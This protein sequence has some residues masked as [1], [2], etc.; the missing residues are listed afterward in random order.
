[1]TT[2]RRKGILVLLASLY[3]PTQVALG[4][5]ASTYP[6]RPLRI[7]VPFAA[8]GP[9][10]LVARIVA[11]ELSRRIGQPVLVENRTGAAGNIGTDFVAKAAPDG[12]TWLV[13][14]SA[15]IAVNLALYR[16]LPYD[17]RTDLR[18]VS[19][20]VTTRT[21]LVV[22]PEVPA[23]NL[24]ELMALAKANP[25][26]YSMGS[27]GAG[28]QPH[29]IQ[30]QMLKAYGA[31]V[32]HVPYKGDAP[33]IADLVGGQISMTVGTVTTVKPYIDAG[34][35]RPLA[36]VGPTRVKALPDVPTFAEL[37]YR[38]EAF[39]FVGPTSL[40]APARTPDAIVERI[41]REVSELVR[42]PDISRRLEA[43]GT[44]P[45]GTLPAQAAASYRA[46]LPG[47]LKMVKD[48]GATAD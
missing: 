45:M 32:V 14:P 33:M 5:S 26:K 41:G 13:A 46:Y 48:T 20:L 8:G 42:S 24:K 2:S 18:M 38:D 3:L 19:E 11:D 10:D 29:I 36:V 37:G 15:P 1:M 6:E 22:R 4:A 7:V 39:Q 21:V 28:S 16:N 30:T 31:E 44:E 34:K 12:Y 43:A 35:V 23:K 47:V 40:L 17:P 27:W 9:T 25:G